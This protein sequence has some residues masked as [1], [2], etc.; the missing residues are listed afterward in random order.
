VEL[1]GALAVIFDFDGTIIDSETA[2]FESH[3]R[4]FAE[5][6]VELTEEEWC[7]GIGIVQPATHWWEWL[8]RRAAAPPDYER[9]REVTRAYFKEHLRLEPMP[10]I[11]ALLDTLEAAGVPRGVASA[12]SARWVVGALEGLGLSARFD[13][14]VT[15][16]AVARPKPAPDV[17][18]EAARR[19]STP[20]GSTVAIEDSGPGLA[21]ARAAGM[22]TVAIP[23]RLNRTH[24]F[25]GADLHLAS[26][27]DLTLEALRG[28]IASRNAPADRGR[29]KSDR[30]A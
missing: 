9:F 28:L 30:P 26:A 23:H 13:A 29:A 16:D 12:A 25:R 18:L 11:S 1:R 14:V 22:R 24:D 19:L 2:E 27:T 21:A 15:G 20:P 3:H 5:H 4:F 7:T 10:G 17:Y 8:R 6:G